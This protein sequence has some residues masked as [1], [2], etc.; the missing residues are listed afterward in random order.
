M[1]ILKLFVLGDIEILITGRGD[2]T[3]KPRSFTPDSLDVEGVNSISST[4]APNTIN[5][6]KVTGNNLNVGNVIIVNDH[7]REELLFQPKPFKADNYKV[8]DFSHQTSAQG[9]SYRLVDINIKKD[10]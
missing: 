2:K 1:V 3:V 4:I 10:L 9:H 7:N 8:T 5:D 6:N